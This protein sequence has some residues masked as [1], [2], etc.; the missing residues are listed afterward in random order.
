VHGAK[1]NKPY[2][3]ELCGGT[4]VTRP[5]ISAWSACRFDSAV[6]AGVRR[7]EALTGEAARKHLDEQDRR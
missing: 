4:H 3:I 5:A 7:I 2:S 1:A 6:A